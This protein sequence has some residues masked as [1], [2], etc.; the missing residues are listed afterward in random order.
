M[1]EYNLPEGR[2]VGEMLLA[3]REAQAAGGIS[4]REEALEF[5]RRWLKSKG[6]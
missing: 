1:R 2:V 6:E 3:I 4:T 5:G